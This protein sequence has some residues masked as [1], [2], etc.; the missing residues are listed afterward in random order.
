MALGKT[1]LI[2]GTYLCKKKFFGQMYLY[3]CNYFTEVSL[4]EEHFSISFW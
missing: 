2:K 4:K 1:L 3:K